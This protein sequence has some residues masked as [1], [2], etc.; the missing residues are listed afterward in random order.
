MVVTMLHNTVGF[1]IK[2]LYHPPS[3]S[4]SNNIYDAIG[5]AYLSM[6]R[7]VLAVNIFSRNRMMVNLLVVDIYYDQF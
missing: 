1:L 7:I 2:N 5:Y 4:S 3:P 6:N